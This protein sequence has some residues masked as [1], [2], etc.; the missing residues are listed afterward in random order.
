MLLLL[1]VGACFAQSTATLAGTVTD[2]SGA[3]VPGAKVTVRSLDTNT[4][5][6]AVSDSAGG[7][8]MPS[9]QPG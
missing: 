5:R 9:L 1:S 4:V 8:V 7:Y 6:E 3:V 2:P